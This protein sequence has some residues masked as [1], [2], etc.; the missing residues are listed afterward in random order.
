MIM[1]THDQ[2][3]NDYVYLKT[4]HISLETQVYSGGIP[5]PDGLPKAPLVQV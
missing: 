5:D 2:I 3:K 1:Y 4:Y